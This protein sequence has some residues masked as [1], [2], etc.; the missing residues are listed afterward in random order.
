MPRRIKVLHLVEDLKVGGL[1]KVVASLA[2]G[3]NPRRFEV[4]VWCLARGGTV[5][6]WLNLSGIP[7]RVLNLSSY[8]R[9][10]PIVRLARR[11]RQSQADIVHTH[12]YFASTFGRL[13]AILAGMGR[14]VVHVHTTDLSLSR[15]HFLIER[16]LAHFAHRVI[17]ISEAVQHFV[18]RV[19]RIPAC[20]TCVIYNG[21][22]WLH[23]E[24]N[25]NL[26]VRL[27]RGL[28]AEDC[29]LASAGALVENKGHRILLDA[30]RLLTP[31]FPALK[32]LLVGDGPLRSEL[33]EQVHRFNLSQN[34]KFT[35]VLQDVHSA[36][37]LADIFVLPTQHREGLSLAILEA[38]Q[39]GL[40]VISTW[41]GGIPEA[42]EHNRSGLLVPPGDAGAL[43]DAIAN[44]VADVS[45]RRSMGE[46]GKK[47]FEERF[48][49]ARMISQIDALYTSITAV[50]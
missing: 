32:L 47:R 36:L 7:V 5:A 48:T 40:P 3:L 15:R 27:S 30:L 42:V 35:G 49:A 33:E 9:P 31:E 14:L 45:L 13:A 41:I 37:V 23:A 46:A 39:H 4:E 19:E 12:G 24:V 50:R 2:T 8:H 6:D 26:H 11:I 17:C 10:L 18:E 22:D 20:K 34:V 29:V 44:L 1:E 21:A 43:K 16:C 25:P 38:M 28:G